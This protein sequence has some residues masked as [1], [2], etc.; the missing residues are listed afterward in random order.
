MSFLNS[1]KESLN[2]MEIAQYEDEMQN[3]TK[4]NAIPHFSS[5]S[6][7]C[8]PLARAALQLQTDKHTAP[9]PSRAGRVSFLAKAQGSGINSIE[10]KFCLCPKNN[11]MGFINWKWGNRESGKSS[12]NC[13]RTGSGRAGAIM[14][15]RR[16]SHYNRTVKGLAD[17]GG[18]E[19]ARQTDSEAKQ[20]L[21]KILKAQSIGWMGARGGKQMRLERLWAWGQRGTAEKDVK[22]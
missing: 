9:K 6:S 4:K 11:E 12:S 14:R 10:V 13:I 16:G 2:S 8:S 22:K 1:N 7:I 15:G 21:W 18:P 17:E 20:K 19:R 3:N 5:Q